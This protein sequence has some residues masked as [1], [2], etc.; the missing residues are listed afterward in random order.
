MSALRVCDV[1]R[2]LGAPNAANEATLEG[3][4]LDSRQAGPGVGFVAL[5]GATRHGAEFAAQALSQ[6]APVVLFEP[7]AEQVPSAA[8]AV[9]QLRAKLGTLANRVYNAPSHHLRVIGV[10]GTNG[11]TSTVQLLTQAFAAAGHLAGSIGTLGAGLAGQLDAGERTTPD[12]L[13]VHRLLARM[14]AQ[15]ATH[16]A[17][18]V[19]SHALD[20]G[21]VDGVRF[22]VAVF[23]NLT[24]DHLDYHGTME[25]YGAAKAKLFAWPELGAVVI[26]R[27]DAHGRALLERLRPG[28]RALSYSARG[29]AAADLVARNIMADAAGLHF[30]LHTPWGAVGVASRLIGRFNVANL[31]AVAGTLALL[32]FGLDAIA[33]LLGGLDPVRGRM[34]RLGGDAAQPLVVVDYA[35]TP[36]ALEQALVNVRAH[37]A[38]RLI[39]V[40]GCGGDR[41]R[42]KRPIMGALAERLSDVAIVTDDNPRSEDGDAI[43]ADIVAGFADRSRARMVRD[44]AEAIAM[45]VR[46]AQAGDTVLIAG[47]GH[48]TYQEIGARKL[49][50]DD[51]EH[52][53]AALEARG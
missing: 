5:R 10:T 22:A 42:A 30:D 41:D 1:L 6:G 23:T 40:F 21:R 2:D 46:Q 18:E 8:V 34:N 33:R 12:V 32:D 9:P 43:V 7:P 13:S 27:D 51:L 37:T 19:S 45:A 50:F 15:G 53:R 36:D 25:A 16:V 35:H 28:L 3:L 44:R 17:M 47:K 4:T 31:L 29:D 26:N 20:Q 48:E 39:C 24:H 11:K 52:A 38:G 14:R 49:P